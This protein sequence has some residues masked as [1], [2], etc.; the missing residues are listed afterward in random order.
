[1]TRQDLNATERILWD[2]ISGY[3]M[4]RAQVYIYRNNQNLIAIVAVRPNVILS[5]QY[6]FLRR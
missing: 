4:H 1:M 6:L 5:R 3:S 2:F